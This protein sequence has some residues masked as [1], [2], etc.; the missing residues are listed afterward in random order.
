MLVAPIE[1]VLSDVRYFPVHIDFER[2]RLIFVQTTRQRLSTSSFIDGRTPIGTGIAVETSLSECVAAK[3]SPP[4]GL[5][6]FIFHVAFCGSTLLA[7]LLDVPGKSLSLREPHVLIDVAEAA[8]SQ[9]IPAKPAVDLVRELLRRPWQPGERNLCKPSNWANNL[10][11]ILTSRPAQIRPLFLATDGR[12]YLRALLRGG[13]D[14]IE[15]ALRATDH[16]L[17]HHESSDDLWARAVSDTVD[18]LEIAARIALISLHLQFLMFGMAARQGSWGRSHLLTLDEIEDDPVR[19]AL[20]AARALD[21]DIEEPDVVSSARRWT[22]RY[23][24]DRKE[25]YSVSRRR[26]ENERIEKAHGGV[27]DR[28]LDWAELTGLNRDPRRIFR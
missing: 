25:R 24:K 5:D 8:S 9:S 18:G 17:R 2:D 6:R 21:L 15:Y 23:A 19:A 26:A 10:I 22:G 11:P 1:E 16:L 12:D 27:I 14:R 7:T 28:A 3:W 13:H 20:T 4:K